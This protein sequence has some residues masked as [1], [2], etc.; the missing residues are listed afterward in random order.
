MSPVR[1]AF[2]YARENSQELTRRDFN[3]I[4]VLESKKFAKTQCV[5][6]KFAEVVKKETYF[7]CELTFY[8]NYP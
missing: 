5:V 4:V 3:A 2:N 7:I 6:C 8:R 1:K